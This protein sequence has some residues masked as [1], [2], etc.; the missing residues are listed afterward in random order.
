MSGGVLQGEGGSFVT[1]LLG[2]LSDLGLPDGLDPLSELRAN[3]SGDGF[4]SFIAA[5]LELFGEGVRG[6]EGKRGGE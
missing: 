1:D 2:A 5:I 3:L 6:S 4:R